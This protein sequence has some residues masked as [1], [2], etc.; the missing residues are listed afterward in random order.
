MI[1]IK[2]QKEKKDIY[3]NSFRNNYNTFGVDGYYQ[4]YGKTYQNPHENVLNKAI[5]K[6]LDDWKD[7]LSLNHVLDLAC[8][9]GE[10][11]IAIQE[12]NSQQKEN[13]NIN[14]DGMDPYTYEIYENR[15]GKKAE[16]Y[17]F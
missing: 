1:I 5:Q 3:S 10:I 12:W 4:K 2:K 16:T 8:G 7:V 15:T 6:L 17:S 13:K 11:T 14:I 9:S